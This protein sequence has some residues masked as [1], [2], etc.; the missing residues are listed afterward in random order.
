[1]DKKKIV[2]GIIIILI[3]IAEFIFGYV[4]KVVD[5]LPNIAITIF[6]TIGG[7]KVIYDGVKGK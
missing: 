2:I 3:G 6:F 1:M 4:T 5:I 7:A